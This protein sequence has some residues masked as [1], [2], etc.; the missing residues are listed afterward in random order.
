MCLAFLWLSWNRLDGTHKSTI[1]MPSQALGELTKA[2]VSSISTTAI[3]NSSAMM[4]N[5][6]ATGMAQA[7]AD[8]PSIPLLGFARFLN[9]L[10]TRSVWMRT[11]S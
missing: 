1:P 11:S 4:M 6:A 8:A 7:L 10:Q 5:L 2:A 9:T 3:P